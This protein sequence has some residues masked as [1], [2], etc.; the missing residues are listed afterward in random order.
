[1]SKTLNNKI[2]VHREIRAYLTYNMWISFWVFEKKFYI[3]KN[4]ALQQKYIGLQVC[5]CLDGS[6]KGW[7][8]FLSIAYEAQWT[9]F[10]I[11]S[12]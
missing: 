4:N 12:L 10:M 1:M 8:D 2:Q 5:S 7:E 9:H 11:L 3:I 6:F